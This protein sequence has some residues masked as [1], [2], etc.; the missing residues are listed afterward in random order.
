[1]GRGDVARRVHE[2]LLS[3]ADSGQCLARLEE[4]RR[5]FAPEALHP[6]SSWFDSC[7]TLQEL[8]ARADSLE[9]ELGAELANMLELISRG[10]VRHQSFPRI[11]NAAVR[12]VIRN[13]PAVVA[14]RDS[15]AMELGIGSSDLEGR[16]PIGDWE[17]YL[18]D[19]LHSRH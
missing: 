10:V 3:T 12:S 6:V 2:A 11:H 16:I 5:E 7:L 9:S 14:L 1:M 17:A 4:M 19:A 8:V 15:I 18:R 13:A